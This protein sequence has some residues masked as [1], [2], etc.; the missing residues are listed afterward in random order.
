MLAFPRGSPAPPYGPPLTVFEP[1]GPAPLLTCVQLSPLTPPALSILVTIILS[2]CQSIQGHI[3]YLQRF[4]SFLSVHPPVPHQGREE[5][6][7]PPCEN[8]KAAYVWNTFNLQRRRG[9]YQQAALVLPFYNMIVLDVS[10]GG[11][12]LLEAPAD[13]LRDNTSITRWMSKG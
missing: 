3:L 10:A 2:M 8:C 1:P 13:A 4:L 6:D 12:L 5:A 9:S 11:V 7:T